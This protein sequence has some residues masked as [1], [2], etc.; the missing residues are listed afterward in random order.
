VPPLLNLSSVAQAVLD[1]AATSGIGGVTARALANEL[2]I[3][4]G[5]LYNYAGSMQ[6]AVSAGEEILNQEILGR[7]AE[8]P[9]SEGALSMLI[10]WATENPGHAS[11]FFDPSRPHTAV[12]REL[13]PRM[14]IIGGHDDA[15]T[16]FEDV[17]SWLGLEMRAGMAHLAQPAFEADALGIIEAYDRARSVAL[18]TPGAATPRISAEQLGELLVEQSVIGATTE[19]AAS[20]R[21]V[22]AQLLLDP[23]VDRWNFRALS[24]GTGVALAALH[25]LGSRG[26]HI[27]RSLVDICTAIF[28]ASREAA[29]GDRSMLFG[30]MTQA[31]ADHFTHLMDDLAAVLTPETSIIAVERATAHSTSEAHDWCT[32]SIVNMVAAVLISAHHRRTVDVDSWT[33]APRVAHELMSTLSN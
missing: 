31:L 21:L 24:S 22:S 19:R 15:M 20:A 32:P 14:E 26:D 17:R 25:G 4:V 5:A 10:G 8:A 28:V 16:R 13:C 18:A 12:P 6:H 2:H 33:I 29:A 23:A 30:I 9:D 27:S 7:V 3:S 1:L 11:L